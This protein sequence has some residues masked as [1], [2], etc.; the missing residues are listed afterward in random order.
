MII[1]RVGEAGEEASEIEERKDW[2]LDSCNNIFEALGIRKTSREAI[3]FIRRVGERGGEDPRPM[4]VGFHKK[5]DR[6]ELLEKA[7]HLRNT[8]FKEVTLVPDITPHQRKEE[9]D[10]GREETRP[11]RKRTGQ[12]TWN[13]WWW[14]RK[15]KRG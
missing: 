11:G 6:S 2:D 4:L 3:K 5:D 1:H 9:A 8:N 10:M 7:K 14:E 13:G 15:E 12:K